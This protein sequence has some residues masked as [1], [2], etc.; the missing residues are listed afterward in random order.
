[1]RKFLTTTTIFVTSF[2]KKNLTSCKWSKKIF[3]QKK[4]QDEHSKLN[5]KPWNQHIWKPQTLK[6]QPLKSAVQPKFMEFRHIFNDRQYVVLLPLRLFFLILVCCIYI[7]QMYYISPYFIA[8]ACWR[9][10]EKGGTFI[11]YKCSLHI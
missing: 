7:L 10:M 4:K 9:N 5:P 1:M 8:Y 2:V 3:Y 6:N 11:K